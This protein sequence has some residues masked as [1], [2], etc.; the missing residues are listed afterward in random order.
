MPSALASIAGKAQEIRAQSLSTL[1]ATLDA[2]KPV[3][4]VSGALADSVQSSMQSAEAAIRAV[5]IETQPSGKA[6]M[7]IAG[8]T[9]EAEL[10]PDLLRAA[11]NNPG[12]LRPGTTLLLPANTPVRPAPDP[13]TL[14]QLTQTN[15][16]GSS[17]GTP[18]PL[19]NPFPPGSLGAAI[20]KLAGLA[21]PLAEPAATVGSPSAAATS[22]PVRGTP[23]AQPLPG[24]LAAP[25][26]QAAA[27]QMP[28]A[29]ALTQ[30]LATPSADSPEALRQALTQ[31]AA[32]RSSPEA[33][34]TPEGL[35]EAVA[36][37]GLFLEANLAAGAPSGPP[38]D[39]KS[40]LVALRA[41]LA[42]SGPEAAPAGKTLDRPGTENAPPRAGLAFGAEL[43]PRQPDLP[44]LA[45][46]AVERLKLMQMASL[47]HPEMRVTDDR[48]QGLRL[49]VSI[50][51][52]TQGPDKPPTA[53]VGL[54]IEHQPPAPQHAAMLE[55]EREANGETEAFPWKVRIALDL[56]ETGPVQAE[57]ALRGQSVSV[58]LWAERQTV[59]LA[60]R[61]SI[62]DLHDALTGA[63][64]DVVKLEIRDGRPQ[65]A[66]VRS[67]PILD[68]LT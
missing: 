47:D 20:A 36:K 4:A 6:L 14:V 68:R 60:A 63:A 10:P 35:R 42:G 66:P 9:V 41:L 18:P 37:S 32:G 51:L 17:V 65:P 12:L 48:A 58:T 38:Q 23:S 8:M 19:A 67:G 50:P 2:V 55:P 39:L 15:V 53:M 61:Q 16:A 44:R 7:Q 40:M 13:A 62:G 33:L 59:A 30:M 54:V 26:L 27:R 24:E 22:V 43:A 5:L 45:E 34:R 11:A 52:A 25:I 3:A 56:E 46:G 29:A 31:L 28:I 57:V 49:A 21:F 64:F 1:M